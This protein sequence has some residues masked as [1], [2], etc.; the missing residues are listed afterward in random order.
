MSEWASIKYIRPF[1]VGCVVGVAPGDMM[2]DTRYNLGEPPDRVPVPSWE[3]TAR[4]GRI[5]RGKPGRRQPRT[6]RHELTGGYRSAPGG[7]LETGELLWL[8]TLQAI[9]LC[10]G[11][12][13]CSVAAATAQLAW[14]TVWDYMDACPWPSLHRGGSGKAFG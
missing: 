1:A 5:P 10:C 12:E 8:G 6:Y 4:A 7:S 11:T 2:A 3:R 13:R 9:G 14:M